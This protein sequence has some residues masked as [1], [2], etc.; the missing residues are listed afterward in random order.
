[1]PTYEYECESCGLK[2]ERR[3]A[4][5]DPP[6]AACPECSGKVQQLISGGTGFILKEAGNYPSE[7]TGRSCT[8]EQTGET[9]CGRRERCD[10]PPCG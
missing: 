2:F 5:T 8:L 1:M 7:Q 6:L 10:K 4:I 9:C 3:R